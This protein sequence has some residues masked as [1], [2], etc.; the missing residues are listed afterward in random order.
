[1]I[2]HSNKT[3]R[4]AVSA[5]ALAATVG[6]AETRREYHYFMDMHYS[7]GG[8]TAKFDNIGQRPYDMY[9]PVG[10]VTYGGAS[11]YPYKKDLDVD[12]ATRELKAPAT[13]DLKR[14]EKKYQIYCAP[15]HGAQGNADGPVAKKF[16]GVR[17]LTN[18]RADTFP[19]SK[20]YHIATAGQGAMAGYAPQVQEQDRWNI[21]AYIKNE[22][23][24]KK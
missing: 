4:I 18:E 15:C 23:Q 19:M 5:L 14:G 9:E 11:A 10:T 12:K 16:A 17:K 7:P 3:V 6:C 21:A 2:K 24:K 1:M 20:I 22:L 13:F 8:D